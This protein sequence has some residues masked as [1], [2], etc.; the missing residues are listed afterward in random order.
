MGPFNGFGDNGGIGG[1]GGFMFSAVPM[2][3]LAVFVIIVGTIIFRLVRGVGEWSR[4][5]GLPVLTVRARIVSKRSKVSHSSD[6]D[7]AGPMTSSTRTSYYVTYQLDSG[8][9]MEFAVRGQEYGLLAEGDVGD[10]TFQGTR[11][12][13]FRRYL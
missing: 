6:P 9:R 10:L 4:N 7:G 8:D 2:F 1:F 11:Y 5:N 13:G 3:I 12:H